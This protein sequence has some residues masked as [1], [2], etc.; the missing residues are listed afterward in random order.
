MYIDGFGDPTNGYGGISFI[1]Y[2]LRVSR[3]DS[4]YTK[5]T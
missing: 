2:P 1:K 3:Q 5:L 4:L